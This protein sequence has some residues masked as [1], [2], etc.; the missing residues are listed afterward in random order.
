M[1]YHLVCTLLLFLFCCNCCGFYQYQAYIP[2]G[3]NVRDPCDPTQIWKGVGH[4]G[5]LGAGPR[6]SFGEDFKLSGF[7]S[8][9]K[10]LS[11]KHQESQHLSEVVF[12]IQLKYD[13]IDL[14]T[15]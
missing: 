12:E 1:C 9:K 3:L 15:H 6:N 11:K 4:M 2:N 10:S 14:I 8:K 7:V 5:P 13:K